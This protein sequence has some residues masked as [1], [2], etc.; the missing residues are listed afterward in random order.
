MKK[1]LCVII[2]LI[3]VYLILCLVGP[4]SS[5]VERTIVIN[6]SSDIIKQ[7]LT[8]LK[9]FHSDWSPWTEK[10]PAMKVTFTGETGKEGNSMLWESNVKDV[11]KGFPEKAAPEKTSVACGAERHRSRYLLLIPDRIKP[12]L[13]TI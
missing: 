12:V 8:D 1:I 10:D 2:G 4:A 6:S 9:F 13:L 5:K 7:K 3:V 11:G